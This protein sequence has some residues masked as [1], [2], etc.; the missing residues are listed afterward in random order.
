MRHFQIPFLSSM[1]HATIKMRSESTLRWAVTSRLLLFGPSCVD[2]FYRQMYAKI[3][4][5]LIRDNAN[6]LILFKQDGTNLK[7][8]YND[9]VNIN[10]SYE[11]ISANCWQ[12]KYGF[13]V[14][15]K[16]NAFT[17]DTEKD[18]MSDCD[19]LTLL[20]VV[21]MSTMKRPPSSSTT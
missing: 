11:R 18:L 13:V 14:I 10:T 5:H 9:Y 8:V 19:T 17:N 3:S 6:L 21:D 15:D 12:Q 1:W 4:K 16:D 7:H 2:C 20:I